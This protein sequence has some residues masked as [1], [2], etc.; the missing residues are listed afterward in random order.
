MATKGE[1]TERKG[2]TK[3]DMD[4]KPQTERKH[5]DEWEQ[6]LNPDRMAGQNLG[7]TSGERERDMPTAHSIKELR[8]RL[9]SEFTDE[10]L[11]GIPVVPE[12]QRLRQGATYLDL[13]D[14]ERREFTATADMVA[15]P[16]RRLVPKSG[17]H[18]SLW[19]RLVGVQNP[20]RT[21]DR[22]TAA[23]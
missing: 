16:D 9:E 23:D 10:E 20:E 1:K 22:R 19:N 14:P 5:P 21:P 8:L 3:A 2:G 4:M 11:A 18:Y 13:N 17:V 6:D 15:G 7:A 12:G